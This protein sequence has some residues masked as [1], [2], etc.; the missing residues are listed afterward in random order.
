MGAQA[1]GTE[2]CSPTFS[3]ISVDF[4]FLHLSSMECLLAQQPRLATA[5]LGLPAISR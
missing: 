4:E 5:V 3:D 1:R 2:P